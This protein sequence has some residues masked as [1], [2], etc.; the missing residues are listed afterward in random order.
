MT[1]FARDHRVVF[2]EEPVPSA[3]DEAS[4]TVRTDAESGVRIATPHL[5]AGLDAKQTT[6]TLRELLDDIVAA[7]RQPVMRWYYTPM[8]IDFSRH[9]D[10]SCTV[11]DCMDELSAFRFAPPELLQREEELLRLADIVFTACTKRRAADTPMSSP[12]RRASTSTISRGPV[13]AS[14]DGRGRHASASTA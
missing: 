10:A 8:M 2:W 1:R 4:L 13:R 5:P 14:R 6:E 11:Y 9:L 3:V 12:S 7:E